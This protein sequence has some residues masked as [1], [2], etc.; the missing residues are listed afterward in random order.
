MEKNN[1]IN[2]IKFLVENFD[3]MYL[4][5]LL[6]QVELSKPLMEKIEYLIEKKKYVVI[7]H[8][9]YTPPLKKLLNKL[10]DKYELDYIDKIFFE[11]IINISSLKTPLI[12][13]GNFQAYYKNLYKKEK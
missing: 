10:L 8:L 11:M 13:R 1:Y 12:E 2:D 3:D 9:F 7:G 4:N 5:I 6:W